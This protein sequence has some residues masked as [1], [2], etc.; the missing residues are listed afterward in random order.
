MRL[1]LLRAEEELD[2]ANRCAGLDFCQCFLNLN[3]PEPESLAD[4]VIMQRP[5]LAVENPEAFALD[6]LL[7]FQRGS[8]QGVIQ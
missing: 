1:L 8:I 5:R 2:S 7:S 4:P 3:S 6:S